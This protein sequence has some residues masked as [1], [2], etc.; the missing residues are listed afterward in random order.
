MAAALQRHM[1][2]MACT[3]HIVTLLAGITATMEEQNANDPEFD[4]T[5]I[6]AVKTSLMGPMAGLGDSFFWGTLLTIAV[7]IGVSFAKEAQHSRTDPVL[8]DHQYSGLFGTLLLLE[9][10]I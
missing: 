5:S 3:P 10:W 4:A 9:V 2:F 6:S 1:E 8:A 7:G